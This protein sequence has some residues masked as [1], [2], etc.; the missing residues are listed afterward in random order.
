VIILAIKRDNGMRFNPAP[1]D[2]IEPGDYLIAMGEP[3]SSPGRTDGA[4]EIMKSSARRDAGD[5][6]RH[7]RAV[8]CAFAHADGEMRARRWLSAYGR[9]IRMSK[10]DRGGLRKG[11]NGGDGFAGGTTVARAGREVRV[12]LFGESPPISAATAGGDV[13]EDATRT[14]VLKNRTTT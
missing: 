5:R 9:N 3:A 14:A 6:S 8:G 1:D 11:N 13:Q 7:Q 12:V 10:A 4:F 2:R